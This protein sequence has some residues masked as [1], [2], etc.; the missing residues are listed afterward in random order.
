MNILSY[1]LY[2]IYKYMYVC[3]RYTP[4]LPSSYLIILSHRCHPAASVEVPCWMA[5]NYTSFGWNQPSTTTMFFPFQ[6]PKNITVDSPNMDS[7]AIEMLFCFPLGSQSTLH[8]L[9]RRSLFGLWQPNDANR[10]VENEKTIG[11]SLTPQ[12]YVPKLTTLK[13]YGLSQIRCIALS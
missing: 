11:L 13:S 1:Y 10:C 4:N 7:R 8:G 3:L 2:I 6:S 9:I 12:R 5:E